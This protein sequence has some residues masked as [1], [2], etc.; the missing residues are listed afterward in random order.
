M[1]HKTPVQIFNPVLCICLCFSVVSLITGCKASDRK[2]GASDHTVPEAYTVT[3]PDADAYYE[4]NSK[5]IS[6]INVK[7]SDAVLTEA[8]TSQA[9]EDRGFT[10]FSVT[11]AYSMDG[12]YYD[13]EDVSDTSSKKHPIYETYYV[14]AAEEVWTIF[15]INGVT[16]ANPVSY[17]LQSTLGVQVIFSETDT[18]MSYDSVT[19]KFYETIPDKSV[20]IVI[21]VEKIDAQT[22]ERLTVEEI[23][24]Y[25]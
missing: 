3:S 5:V 9:L 20:L 7:D 13:S 4:N 21:T 18:V 8:E 23:D 6:E 12:K 25:V 11:S 2:D 1:K 24:R 14:T 15:V 22:L 10:Q 17:N 16:M 19:N